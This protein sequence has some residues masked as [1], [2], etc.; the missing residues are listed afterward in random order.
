MFI[1]NSTKPRK[2]REV[3]PISN[4]ALFTTGYWCL[5]TTIK[6]WWSLTKHSQLILCEGKQ[7]PGKNCS[8]FFC[9]SPAGFIINTAATRHT[10]RWQ[11]SVAACS[12]ALIVAWVH[13]CCAPGIT[14][15][16]CRSQMAPAQLRESYGSNCDGDP[17]MD[18]WQFQLL[19]NWIWG[20]FRGQII[21]WKWKAHRVWGFFSTE[22]MGISYF[23]ST[24]RNE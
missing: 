2:Q 3:K 11:N 6:H 23:T 15:G 4:K 19:K 1:P 20:I 24:F 17:Q 12:D 10:A 5:K 14:S 16:L 13:W 21:I 22:W 8:W 7:P 9:D 18:W